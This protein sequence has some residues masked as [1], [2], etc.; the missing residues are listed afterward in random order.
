VVA[1]E[2]AVFR[3]SEQEL[4]YMGRAIQDLVRIVG[5]IL[6]GLTLLSVRNR[7]KR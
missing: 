4:S 2:G 7:V 5:P 3:A 6:I 1:L